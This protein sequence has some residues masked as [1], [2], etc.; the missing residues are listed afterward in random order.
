MRKQIIGLDVGNSYIKL[1]HNGQPLVYYNTVKEVKYD[2]FTGM[3]PVSQFPTFTY[4]GKKYQVG[5]P[6]SQGSGGISSTRY[7]EKQFRMEVLFALAQVVKSGSNIQLVTGVPAY[8]IENEIIID[9][10]KDNLKGRH[11]LEVDDRKVRFEISDVHVLSQGMAALLSHCFGWDGEIYQKVT[12][13]YLN[14]RLLVIDTGWGTTE[15]IEISLR[16]GGVKDFATL[17]KGIKEVVS[18]IGQEINRRKP[19]LRLFDY[20]ESMYDLD[21]AVRSGVLDM[22]HVKVP[23]EALAKSHYEDFA[24]EVKMWARNSRFRLESYYEI[25]LAGGGG[26]VLQ[27]AYKDAFKPTRTAVT[28]SAQLANATG[29]KIWGELNLND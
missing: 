22:G 17:P 18:S 6:G 23:V 20:Y 8:H 4:E 12:D 13:N 5:F 19:Q 16:E 14:Q 27:D 15:F 24:N 1:V 11:E 10:L 26:I 25:L 7:G 9:M 21:E 3:I 29:Y 2:K 28:T